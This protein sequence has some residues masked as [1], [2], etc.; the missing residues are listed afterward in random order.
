MRVVLN[1]AIRELNSPAMPAVSNTVPG[2]A[3]S[4][5]RSHPYVERTFTFAEG[6]TESSFTRPIASQCSPAEPK[7][8]F[9]GECRG[10]IDMLTPT[11]LFGHVLSRNLT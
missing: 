3:T 7:R 1:E 11:A 2:G 8:R 4:A 9:I 5:T 10:R 6:G